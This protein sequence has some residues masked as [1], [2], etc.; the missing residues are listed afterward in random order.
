MVVHT[1]IYSYKHYCDACGKIWI[2][3]FQFHGHFCLSTQTKA[4]ED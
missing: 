3:H 1:E 4:K 2:N